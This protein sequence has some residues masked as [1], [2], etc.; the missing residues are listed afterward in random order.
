MAFLR[1]EGD[2]DNGNDNNINNNGNGDY[3][4]DYTNYIWDI[5]MV[6]TIS[7]QMSMFEIAKGWQISYPWHY[8]SW[9]LGKI[10]WCTSYRSLDP[11]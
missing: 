2:E 9:L 1:V 10:I 4:H 8:I 11:Y 3:E 6:M 7:V 5:R